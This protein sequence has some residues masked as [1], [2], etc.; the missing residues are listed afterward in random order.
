MMYLTKIPYQVFLPKSFVQ[1]DRRNRISF[2]LNMS[3][4][5]KCGIHLP[6]R[7][8]L[9]GIIICHHE[10]L[11]P[12]L[13][14]P[15]SD[16]IG[17]A[18]FLSQIHSR[19]PEDVEIWKELLTYSSGWIIGSQTSSRSWGHFSVGNFWVHGGANTVWFCNNFK[20]NLWNKMCQVRFWCI[21]SLPNFVHNAPRH[22]VARN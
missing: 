4:F 16:N 22:A 6:P 21:F 8:R 15:V 10:S 7:L 13:P 3:Y 9:F 14:P 17:P 2:R 19:L 12:P 20:H 18:Y 11:S 1:V 5:P